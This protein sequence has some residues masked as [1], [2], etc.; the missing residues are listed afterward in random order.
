[1]RDYKAVIT[2]LF[3]VYLF[4]NSAIA[5]YALGI[6]A[7]RQNFIIESVNSKMKLMVQR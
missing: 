2:F 4:P 7:S 1:M 3:T 6:G 5:E